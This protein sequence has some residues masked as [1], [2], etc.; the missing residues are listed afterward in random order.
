MKIWRL[1]TKTDARHILVYS[2]DT[3]VY[4]IGLS[5]LNRI[6]DKDIYVQ[7]NVPRSQIQKSFT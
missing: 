5:V 1:V 7:L 2:S 4:N 3:D 6:S